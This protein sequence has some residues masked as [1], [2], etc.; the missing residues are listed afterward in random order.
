M[1]EQK[2]DIN[3]SEEV[4]QG[5]Y[6]NL[7]IISH[8]NSEFIVDFVAMLPGMQKGNVRSRVVMTPQNAKR[9]LNALADNVAK[10]ES[11][12]GAIDDNPQGAIPPM[13][14]GGGMA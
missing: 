2:I 3:L 7:A 1:S 13:M 6:S 14:S 4:A 12:N 10:F 8:S 5:V 9:L 11:Q